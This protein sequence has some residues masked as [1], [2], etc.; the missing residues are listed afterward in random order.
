MASP[1]LS[2]ADATTPP[3]ALQ[4]V[5]TPLSRLFPQFRGCRRGAAVA[6]HP[7]PPKPYRTP[8]GVAAIRAGVAL[9]FNTKPLCTLKIETAPL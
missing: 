6:P 2:G 5:A 1:V 9:H 3:V 7:G 8:G 4:G